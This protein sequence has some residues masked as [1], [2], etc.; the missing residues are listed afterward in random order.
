MKNKSDKSSTGPGWY[1]LPRTVLTPEL[2]RDLQLLRNRSV[3]DPHR[4]YKKE[5]SKPEV[6]EFSQIGTVIEGPTEYFSGRLSNKERKRT[7]LEEVLA[8]ESATKRFKSKY[9]QIQ[10]KKTDGKKAHYK[11]VKALRSKG[12]HRG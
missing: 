12:G 10:A 8:G 1:N 5:A 4:H 2:K 11:K 3:L 7:F 6:P 9:D